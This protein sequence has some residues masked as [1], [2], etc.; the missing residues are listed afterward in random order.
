[1]IFLLMWGDGVV[2]WGNVGEGV[3]GRGLWEGI[4]GDTKVTLKNVWASLLVSF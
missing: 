3:V 1:M 2:G 4:E